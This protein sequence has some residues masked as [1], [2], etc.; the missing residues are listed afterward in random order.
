MFNE[1]L[2]GNPLR[3]AIGTLGC[4]SNYADTVQLQAALIELGAIPCD[5]NSAADVYVLNTCT[6]TD[7]A[8]KE[9]LKLIRQVRAK[10][11]LAK[12]VVTGCLAAAKKEELQIL[13]AV[14]A[15]V[16]LEDR[17]ALLRAILGND[18][19]IGERGIE[20]GKESKKLV[21]LPLQSPISA[22]ISGPNTH[23]GQVK[24]RARYHLRVQ[25]GCQNYCTFC[26]IPSIKPTLVSRPIE[27]VLADL[28]YL[29]RAGYQEVVITGT[30]LG[31][32]GIDQGYTLLDLLQALD[33]GSAIPRVR[34]S[35]LD[36]NDLMPEIIDL[37]AASK[38]FCR[39]FHLCLQSFSDL[40]L[41][42]MNRRYL[43]ED[44][45]ELLCYLEQQLSDCCIGSDLI[46]G[47]PG[48]SRQE[49]EKA[50]EV[51]LGLPISYLHVFPFSERTGTAATRLG[52][53]VPI[54]ERRSRAAEW[55]ELG[56]NRRK[57]FHRSLVGRDLEVV[58]E[59]L[60]QLPEGGAY[61]WGTSREYAPVEIS[62][63][64]V[65]TTADNGNLTVGRII[66]VRPDSYNEAEKK[67][68][69]Q[70]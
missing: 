9:A 13:S 63:S 18:F 22:H 70:M 26:I 59:R 55:R 42:R 32:Y 52:G 65:N 25:E 41:K 36:P 44:V 33:R 34:I 30:H 67:L 54:E 23:M 37:F 45:S 16:S 15:V 39:H 12:I 47:F 8:D 3:V 21:S 10:F 53:A 24:A 51:F 64:C 50:K 7:A 14:D 43:L 35:S 49:V 56:E 46:A 58:I 60:L 68:L 11:P 6:V 5:F 27:L 61:A 1:N 57:Q 28:D 48:E 62:A 17:P 38:V 40:I 4:R 66:N 69:C 2:S 31:A 19:A 20:E 29:A